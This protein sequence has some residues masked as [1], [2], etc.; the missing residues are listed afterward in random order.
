MLSVSIFDK[1]DWLRKEFK[2]GRGVRIL[3]WFGDVPFPLILFFFLY[4]PQKILKK[5]QK[6]FKIDELVRQDSF[7]YWVFYVLI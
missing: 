5:I 2:V 6:N 4:F 1:D 7:L 3:G